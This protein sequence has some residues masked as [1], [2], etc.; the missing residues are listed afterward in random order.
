VPCG[1]VRHGDHAMEQ[2]AR[3]VQQ[4]KEPIAATIDD[5]T[6]GGRRTSIVAT[7]RL[8]RLILLTQHEMAYCAD[9]R[10]RAHL[11]ASRE[12]RR[13]GGSEKL[14]RAVLYFEQRTACFASQG[15]PIGIADPIEDDMTNSRIT[16]LASF[17]FGARRR[18]GRV[19]VRL[20]FWIAT[21]ILL[22]TP[23]KAHAACYTVQG[24]PSGLDLSSCA[25]SDANGD[26]TCWYEVGNQTFD[27]AAGCDCSSAAQIAANACVGSIGSGGGGGATSPGAASS[28]TSPPECGGSPC[29][30]QCCNGACIASDATCCSSG[31]CPSGQTCVG[32]GGCIPPDATDCKDGTYCDGGEACAGG[33]ICIPSDAV[34]CND[35]TYCQ[36][37]TT[38]GSGGGC[39]PP[40]S[41]D[42]GDGTYC[43]SGVG[44]SCSS[45]T[46]P[47]CA[48][49]EYLCGGACCP[50]S[51]TCCQGAC[52]A[53]GERC[54]ECQVAGSS[55]P[56]GT[57][58]CANGTCPPPGMVCAGPTF[59]PAAT[60]LWCSDGVCAPAGS[61]CCGQGSLGGSCCGHQVYCTNG[62]ACAD[63]GGGVIA[64]SICQGPNGSIGSNG[65]SGSSESRM[66]GGRIDGSTFSGGSSGGGGAQPGVAPGSGNVPVTA[67]ARA[68][69]QKAAS[70]TPTM[71]SPHYTPRD[72]LFSVA[73]GGR[74]ANRDATGLAF[75]VTLLG[76]VVIRRRR[77][78]P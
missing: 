47:S 74:D 68:S 33:G 43:A 23:L 25:T 60:P 73:G 7:S 20:V 11:R 9:N 36:T 4:V 1:R 62:R 61:Q 16:R 70:A 21:L 8:Q 54:N 12:K 26:E 34:D 46:A 5:A 53:P 76:G 19:R 15:L 13:G 48:V 17:A 3:Q 41:T 42:C 75:A 59:C 28:G 66:D 38:C 51:Q 6:N 49:N 56:G 71:S 50:A 32:A 14:Q 63:C 24:C 52:L 2:R 22:A 69:G 58:C 30:E 64:C 65:S 44:C 67:Q 27:C 18:F 37:G 45:P 10:P 57:F 78:T 55:C 40:G 35:G 39:I 31:Y 72:C 77:R 29:S